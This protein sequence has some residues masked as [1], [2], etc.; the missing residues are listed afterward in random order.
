MYVYI[1]I[2]ICIYI[3][4][5]TH[6]YIYMYMYV[7]ICIALLLVG[8]GTRRR[9]VSRWRGARPGCRAGTSAT[10]CWSGGEQA[11]LCVFDKFVHLIHPSL[12]VSYI[13]TRLTFNKINGINF[14][15]GTSATR[16]WPGR[17]MIIIILLLL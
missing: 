10:R 15:A 8:R 4:V 5:Y 13:I 17:P 9:P 16:C 7:Y 12:N 14:R 3:Y 1:Y 11:Q 6:I 2:Y